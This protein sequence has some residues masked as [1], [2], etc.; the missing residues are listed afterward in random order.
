V[1]PAEMARIHTV[2]QRRGFTT[3]VSPLDSIVTQRGDLVADFG[4]FS[5]PFATPLMRLA[6]MSVPVEVGHQAMSEE[7]AYIMSHLL[8]DVTISGTAHMLPRTW[9]VGGKTGTSSLSDGWFVGFDGRTTVAAWLGSDRN[10]HDLGPGEHGATVALPIFQNFMARTNLA[11]T[12]DDW[13]GPPPPNVGFTRIDP[14][15]G[16]LSRPGEPGSSYPF[17]RGTEPVE[18]APSQGTRQAEQIDSLLMDF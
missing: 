7:V 5:D 11:R 18:L 2:F 6:R 13:P 4:H 1:R 8:R 17:I 10:T 16:L 3:E 15:T 9:R 14:Q 12:D